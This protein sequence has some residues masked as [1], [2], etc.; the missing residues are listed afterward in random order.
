MCKEKNMSQKSK[1]IIFIQIMYCIFVMCLIFNT[2]TYSKYTN[3]SEGERIFE[4]ANWKVKIEN[5]DITKQKECNIDILLNTDDN[6]YVTEGKVAPG[7]TANGTFTLDTSG[8]EVTIKYIITPGKIMYNE[9]E[10]LDFKIKMI[11]ANNKILECENGEYTDII[12][13]E[14]INELIEF[15]IVV[16]W[17]SNDDEEDTIKGI[18]T[19]DLSI[20]INVRVE[21]YCE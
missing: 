11:K 14:N 7:I 18:E 6:K 16:E 13:L 19:R 1:K 20:P 9:E 8:S 10:F 12:E 5:I 2:K 3:F 21:Q 17:Q 15:T 4:T